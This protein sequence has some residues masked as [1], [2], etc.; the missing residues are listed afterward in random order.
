VN[1]FHVISKPIYGFLLV[2]NSNLGPILHH[3]AATACNGFQGHPRSM[4]FI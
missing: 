1:D 4:I 3:L 2:I